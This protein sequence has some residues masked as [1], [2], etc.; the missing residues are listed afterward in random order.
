MP[1][2][3]E[4]EEIKVVPFYLL[5]YFFHYPVLF[6]ADI[7]YF[8]AQLSGNFSFCA[9]FQIGGYY[10]SLHGRKLF[11]FTFQQ[12]FAFFMEKYAFLHTLPGFCQFSAFPFP[13]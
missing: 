9:L 8:Y 6:Y 7:C 1:R 4:G 13:H 12:R 3:S 10:F 5:P 2:W 11:Y